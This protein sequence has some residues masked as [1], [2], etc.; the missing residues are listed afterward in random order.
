MGTYIEASN[1]S[2]FQDMTKKELN[3]RGQDIMLARV[4]ENYYAIA[5]RCPHLGGNLAAGNLE[6]TIITCPRHGSQF[7]ITDGHTVRWLKGTGPMAAVGK[8]LKSPQPV[9][10]F[11]VKV[12]GDSIMVEV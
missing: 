3:L 2:D 6:G 9:K 10:T 1:T 5:N 7:D 8:V 4:G 11:K 12:E